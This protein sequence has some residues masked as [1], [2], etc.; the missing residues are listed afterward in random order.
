MKKTF[1]IF[2]TFI[3]MT[4][5]CSLISFAAD[6]ENKN[7]FK[8]TETT[9]LADIMQYFDLETYQNYSETEKRQLHLIYIKDLE[10]TDTDSFHA[11]STQ[12]KAWYPQFAAAI[13]SNQSSPSSGILSYSATLKASEPCPSLYLSAI[14][15]DKN[16]YVVDEIANTRANSTQVNVANVTSGLVSGSEY[17][18]VYYGIVT[19]PAGLVPSS[20][21]VTSTKYTTIR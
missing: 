21:V 8:I 15:Y 4:L 20:G 12:A 1:C 9:S 2:M 14:A 18:V 11:Y 16:G 6:S 3:L 5:N 19:A 10:Q 13:S 17:H 7:M